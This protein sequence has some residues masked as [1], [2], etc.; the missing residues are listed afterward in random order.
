MTISQQGRNELIFA[1]RFSVFSNSALMILKLAVGLI[2][3]SISVIS[4]AIHSGT[5]LIAALI[6]NFSVRRSTVPA[7]DGHKF[8]HGK[9]ES[10]SGS[11]EAA[12]ILVAAAIIIYEAFLRLIEH[13]GLQIIEI[14]IL[15]MGISAALNFLVSRYLM[16]IAK[17]HHSLA[18]E[19]DAL[20]L[21]TDVWTSLGVFVGLVLV[22]IT[23]INEIDSLVAIGVAALIIN[24]SLRLTRKSTRELLDYSLSKDEERVIQQTILEIVGETATY[25]ELRTRRSGRERFVDFHL[26]VPRHLEVKT[27]H[28]M[29]DEIENK[30]KLRLPDS[31]L[32]I[33]VE[34]CSEN[35]AECKSAPICKG[36]G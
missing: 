19:A 15:I 14:G 11:I 8:G 16:R 27:A 3:A 6:A 13:S 5:D 33:H 35:C 23:G 30:I 28:Q 7:D 10:L 18:L 22:W 1:A 2:T 21:K 9:Y 4:E 34:P 17:R 29:C 25:H 12:L 24:A 26:V 31:N 36:A 32:T 20:H